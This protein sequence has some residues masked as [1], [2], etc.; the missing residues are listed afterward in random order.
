[1]ERGAAVGDGR[2]APADAAPAA[3]GA[4]ADPAFSSR[5]LWLLFG[6]TALAAALRLL[7]L[8]EWSFWVDEAHTYRD[9]VWLG[10]RFWESRVSIYP[11]SYGLL[12]LLHAMGMPS[13]EGWMRLPFAFFGI[14]SVPLTA[15]VGRSLVGRRAAVLAAGLL[16]LS[17]WHLY[18]SQCARSYALTSCLVLL[19]VGI[20]HRGM[21][22]RSAALVSTGFGVALL[23]GLSHP[24]GYFMLAALA[25]PW[26]VRHVRASG[27]ARGRW[28]LWTAVLGAVVLAVAVLLPLLLHFRVSK[29]RFSLMHLAQTLAY[30][31]SL[32][33]L[34][35]AGGGLALLWSR[36]R[37]DGPLLLFSWAVVPVATL[38][39]LSLGVIT[40]TAQYAFYCLPAL[41]LLAAVLMDRAG[42]ELGAVVRQGWPRAV[43][44]WTP[45][46]VLALHFAGQAFLYYRN[47]G[48]R[49]HWREASRYVAA[50][51]AQRKRVLTTNHPSLSY[52]LDPREFSD[53]RVGVPVDV[54]GLAD[55]KFDNGRVYEGGFIGRQIERAREEGYALFAVVTE[56]E[57][58]EMDRT[59]EAD[60]MLRDHFLQV[61]RLPVSTGPKDM[62][63]LVYRL[64][65]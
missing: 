43:V 60:R 21:R 46:A 61:L 35:A 40:V 16:A 57:L 36:P 22:Q 27:S 3:G 11:L 49:P 34:A 18:W 55:F 37:G 4:A 25:V 6:V 7:R 9:A 32:P 48:D 31:A 23:A 20:A 59:G 39:A 53:E 51:P 44:R 33:L 14:L 12:K 54:V 64:P 5:Q 58:D 17:P 29:S 2:P 30:F 8:G 13:S 62:T 41:C 47:G 10:D 38:V 63:I 24:S 1:M 28:I 26:W 65:R 45:V 19:A 52:Y 42:A 15:L 50:E 56:P